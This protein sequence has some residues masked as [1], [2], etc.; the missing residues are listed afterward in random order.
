M[1][2]QA[3]II[4][5]KAHAARLRER[6]AGHVRRLKETAGI[7]PGLAVVLVGLELM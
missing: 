5:G 7:T 4:D 3:V 2:A 6:I 1:T